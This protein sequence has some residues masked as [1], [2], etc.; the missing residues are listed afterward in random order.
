MKVWRIHLKN[1]EARDDTDR[2]NL[3]KMCLNEEIIGVGWSKITTRDDSE[4]KIRKQAQEKYFGND[5]Q[6]GLRAVNAMRKM[7]I[8][9]LIWTRLDPSVIVCAV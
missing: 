3:K 2:M 1:D 6:A 9:D 4:D 7:R 5:A 8:G